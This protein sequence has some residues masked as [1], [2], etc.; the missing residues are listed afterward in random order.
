MY[1][2]ISRDY[3]DKSLEYSKYLIDDIIEIFNEIKRLSDNYQFSEWKNIDI[4]VY[5]SSMLLYDPR[6][7]VDFSSFLK[8]ITS[9]E[10]NTNIDVS[11]YVICFKSKS[12]INN[13]YDIIKH[14]LISMGISKNSISINSDSTIMMIKCHY[15]TDEMDIFLKFLNLAYNNVNGLL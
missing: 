9:I 2:K 8:T 6:S 4:Q 15:L 3:Y 5:N 1:T 12:L 7:R 10:C 11:E 13:L 14:R